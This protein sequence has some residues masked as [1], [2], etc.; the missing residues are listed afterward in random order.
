VRF[1]LDTNV[2]SEV[3]RRRPDRN[4]QEWWASVRSTD[5][6]LS[7]LTIGEVHQGV[8]RLR[9]RDPLQASVYEAW[10]TRLRH[11]YAD[12]IVPVSLQVAEEWGRLNSSAFLPAIDSLL[13][14]TARVHDLTFVTRNV[15]DVRRT[16]VR[17][18]DPFVRGVIVN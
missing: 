18:L 16:G 4:V 11:D 15:A 17:L 12:R 6:Y 7:V 13:A 2:V 5:I 8:E 9:R 1:L 10:L 14:A 3:Q